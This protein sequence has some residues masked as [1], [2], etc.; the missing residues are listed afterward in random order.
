MIQIQFCSTLKT[1]QKIN[2]RVTNNS[3]NNEP[4]VFNIVYYGKLVVL[5]IGP[6][7]SME[8]TE[9]LTLIQPQFTVASVNVPLKPLRA[10]LVD[11]CKAQV[12]KLLKSDFFVSRFTLQSLKAL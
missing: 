10:K 5:K 6:N 4:S 12:Q 9:S 8:Q 2:T 7:R 3:E 1:G 11:P